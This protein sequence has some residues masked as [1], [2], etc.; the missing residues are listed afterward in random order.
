[1]NYGDILVTD[2][3]YIKN[4]AYADKARFDALKLINT[5]HE[6][7]DGCYIFKLRTHIGTPDEDTRL[8]ELGVD[9]GRV[10]VLQA[11]F[12]CTVTMDSG[13]SGHHHLTKA[14]LGDTYTLE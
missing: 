1:M 13:L 7:D 8:I 2:P 9:S 12:E 6:G 11:E 3:C 5:L 14:Q 4:V 10:W